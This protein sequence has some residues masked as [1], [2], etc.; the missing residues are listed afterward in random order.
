MKLRLKQRGDT[1]VEVLIA[2]A[3][4]SI[5]LTGAMTIS[6]NSLKQIRAAQERS[7][8]Q[9]YAQ[10]TVESLDQ[11]IADN[12]N[13][14]NPNPDFCIATNASGVRF[15]QTDLSN[16]ACKFGIY[17][18][19]V[20]RLQNNT[21]SVTVNWDGVTGNNEQLILTYRTSQLKRTP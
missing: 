14:G 3:V 4:V 13:A 9:A 2:T 18:Q 8:A 6:N 19:K 15:A 7:E 17:T 11:F 21:F 10:S 20:T 1:I 5:V 16:A 12:P